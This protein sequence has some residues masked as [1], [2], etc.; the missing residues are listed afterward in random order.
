MAENKLYAA[1][2]F[3]IRW[4][5]PN[6]AANPAN[7]TPAEINATVDVT[8]SVAWDSFGFGTQASNTNSDPSIAD[9]G[10]VQARGFAQFG[11][12]ISL[13]YPSNY[14]D[15]TDGNLITFQAFEEPLT[16]G[17]LLLK[18]DGEL[19]PETNHNAAAGEFWQVYKVISDGWADS[20][21]GE[22]NFKYA[23]TFQPQGDIYA[24]LIVGVATVTTPA[25]VGT[26]DYAVGG[27]TPLSTYVT[28]R[29]LYDVP[30]EFTGYP[31]WFSWTSSAP[32]I[33]SVD[34][35]GVV[36]AL[37]AGTANITA[38]E[39]YSLVSS[40]ALAITVTS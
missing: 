20:V 39:K 35:N 27:K 18:V 34:A 37:A 5:L 4:G 22:N 36:T 30:A 15:T 10:N 28:G 16:L 13:F 8:R 2:N 23:I 21:T 40:T 24:D 11:G 31:G 33:A 12:A 14:T 19:T 25:P 1:G 38:T 7:P 17:Y 6:F 32:D 29:K 3:V 26:A 9:K